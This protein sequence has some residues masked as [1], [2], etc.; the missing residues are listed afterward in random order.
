MI[1]TMEKLLIKNLS[2]KKII[3]IIKLNLKKNLFRFKKKKLFGR[4][5]SSFYENVRATLLKM[6]ECALLCPTISL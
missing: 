3:L 6:A 2:K 1:G 5:P 4:N